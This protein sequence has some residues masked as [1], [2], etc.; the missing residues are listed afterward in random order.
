MKDIETQI[1]LELSIFGESFFV[2]E[3]SSELNLNPTNF[4]N[5]GDIIPVPR[6]VTMKDKIVRRRQ[7]TAWEYSTGFIQTLTLVDVEKILLE[8]FSNK[9]SVLQSF[10]HKNELD[11]S[12]NAVVEIV[13]NNTPSLTICKELIHFCNTLNIDLDIDLY[14]INI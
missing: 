2:K 8:K 1:K 10:I 6:G 11:V 13:N 12:I 4:W 7:E 9:I 5:K 3:L 14:L